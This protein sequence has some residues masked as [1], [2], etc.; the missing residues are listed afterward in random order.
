ME[1]GFNEEY[2]KL[3]KA[4]KEAV[5]T[6][7]GPV[8]VVAGPGTGKTQILALRIAN[9]LKKTDIKADGILALTFTNSAVE[10]MKK[11]LAQYIGEAGEKV[12]IFTFHSFGMKIIE[13]YYKVLGLHM[14]PTLLDDADTAIIFGEI[15]EKNDWQYLR[16]RGDSSRYFSDL[17]SLIT[18]LKRERISTEYFLSEVEKEMGAIESDPENIS[19][20]GESKG[21]LKKEVSNKI[22][23]LRRSGE[24]VK[25]FN[26]YEEVKKQRNVFDYDDVLEN[27]VKITELSPDTVSDIREQYLYILVDEHQD[28]SAVQNQFLKNVWGS[29][30]RPDIFV[31]GDDRQLIYGFSGASIDHFQGFKKTFKKSKLITLVDNYRSTQVILDASH[32]LLRSIMT[33]EKLMSQSKENH[34]LRLVEAKY[35]D[36]EIVVAAMDIKKKMKKG[37]KA[38]NCAILVPKNVEVRSALQILHEEGLEVSALDAFNLFDEAEAQAFL[39]VLRIISDPSVTPALAVSFFDKSSGITPLEAHTY[40]ALQNMR[41][42]SLAKIAEEKPQKLFSETNSVDKWVGKLSRWKKLS[43]DGSVSEIVRTVGTEFLLE[44]ENDNDKLVS[45]K[46]ILD[47]ILSL[48]QKEAEKNQ[49]LTLRELV[50]FLGRLESYGEEVPLLMGE[51]EGVKVLTLHSSKGLEFD[52]VWIAHMDESSM[53]RGRKM[54]FVLPEAIAEK[55]LERDA[56]VTKRKLY[57]AITRAKRFCTISYATHS[58]GGGEQEVSKVIKDLPEEI[59]E[60]QKIKNVPRKI[61][62]EKNTDISNLVKLVAEKYRERKVSVSLLNNFFECPWKW[63]FRNLLQLPEPKS[64]SLEFGSA[65]HG[66]IDKILKLGHEPS[67]GELENLGL[68]KEVMGVVSRW[69][70][71]RLPEIKLQ[72]ETEK[73]ISTRDNRFPLLN[74]YGKIDLVEY[75]SKNELRVTDFKTGS[76]KKKGEIEKLDEEGRMSSYLRQLA[77]YSYL[78]QNTSKADVRKSRLEFLEAKNKKEIFYDRIITKGEIELLLKDIADYDHLVKTGEWVNRPCNYNSYGK[79]TV[80]EYC[81]MA[82]Y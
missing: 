38:N 36:D 29:L 24:F 27:L 31:G 21:Q 43:Q 58:S 81:K 72:R 14:P 2:K 25:F 52:Y 10:A 22:E 39:R 49:E 37:V 67:L 4:Q 79:A 5:D 7:D 16:P 73:S 82:W 33:E 40:L 41:E 76:V 45:G 65:V 60:K 3:N 54:G 23:G 57:V 46:E 71:A 56:D 19:Q 15:L 42:F 26:L 63:Y 34:I 11:R 77:M 35:P 55:V 20:R 61:K 62:K 50:S 12:N 69:V 8:M 17:K 68:D 64:E 70:S 1:V 74:I 32:A 66:A 30:E 75:L 48:I 78:L 9:I 51:K 18:L 59:F 6:I 28:S 53:S 13:E 44:G 80:C 47:T